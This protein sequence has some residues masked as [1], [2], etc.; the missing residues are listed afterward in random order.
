MFDQITEQ[1]QKSMKPMSELAAINVKATEQLMQQQTSLFTGMMNDGM[2]FAQGLSGQKD[3]AAVMEAQKSYAE[4]VQEKVVSAAK[5]A[6]AVITETQEKA[7]EV[8]KGA[9]AEAKETAS[10][11]ATKATAKASK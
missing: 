10:A 2:T 4:G 1:F 5:D 6:Y 3:V 8:L 9:F 11:V 7:S